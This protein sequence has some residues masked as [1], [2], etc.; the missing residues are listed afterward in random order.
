MQFVPAK[1]RS[2]WQQRN[3]SN[4]FYKSSLQSIHEVDER[5][6]FHVSS[7][8]ESDSQIYLFNMAESR[9]KNLKLENFLGIYMKGMHFGKKVRSCLMDFENPSY[10]NDIISLYQQFSF[11]NSDGKK[12]YDFRSKFFN[13][14]FKISHQQSEKECK[15]SKQLLKCGAHKVGDKIIED[16]KWLKLMSWWK[17][18]NSIEQHCSKLHQNLRSNAESNLKDNKSTIQLQNNLKNQL[19]YLNLSDSSVEISAIKCYVDLPQILPNI[20][21]W[22]LS[23]EK[24]FHKLEENFFQNAEQDR[25][26]IHFLKECSHYS[27]NLIFSIV[28]LLTEKSEIVNIMQTVKS[29]AAYHLGKFYD[30]VK[31]L[32][33]DENNDSINELI[34]TTVANI[35]IFLTVVNTEKNNENYCDF[36]TVTSLINRTFV[37]Q[38]KTTAK[39][40]KN[41]FYDSHSVITTKLVSIYLLQTVTNGII[42]ANRTLRNDLLSHN[43][44][45]RI[46]ENKR[47]LLS[48]GLTFESSLKLAFIITSCFNIINK[49]KKILYLPLDYIQ[50]D[51]VAFLNN[52]HKES[53]SIYQTEVFR[54]DFSLQL[55][56]LQRQLSQKLEKSLS[57]IA[58]AVNIA[59][60]ILNKK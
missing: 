34:E 22:N 4:T 18:C 9:D 27:L 21:I 35:K 17:M 30:T 3:T 53:N 32:L 55:K 52:V 50:Y 56:I 7:F 60:K 51:F 42:L 58:E 19:D 11:I 16:S 59:N 43:L 31:A 13:S 41:V 54:M 45:K 20:D 47:N 48:A 2:I 40:F 24:A 57:S 23:Q 25:V 15:I 44:L 28:T 36:K 6:S 12:N 26:C 38:T 14:L 49:D 5:D 1:K 39:K 8:L 37:V 46:C 10:I 33:R 29:I